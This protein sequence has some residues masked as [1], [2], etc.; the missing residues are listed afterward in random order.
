MVLSLALA[1]YTVL[2]LHVATDQAELGLE[3]KTKGAGFPAPF[4]VL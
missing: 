4:V 1:Q 2:A 3:G